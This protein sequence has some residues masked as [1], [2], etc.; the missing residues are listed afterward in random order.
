MAWRGGRLQECYKGK[1]DQDVCDSFRGLLISDHM[2]KTLTS[3]LQLHLNERYTAYVT[4]NQFGAVRRRGTA[5]AS[6]TLRSFMDACRLMGYSIAIIFVDLSK[7]FDLIVRQL[8]LGWDASLETME[9]KM[10]VLTSLGLPE[11]VAGKIASYISDHGCVL[12][13]MGVDLSVIELI[14]SLH[15]RAWFQ[16]RGGS[17]FLITKTGSRQGCKLG[18]LVFNLLYAAVLGQF[19]L[20]CRELGVGFYLEGSARLRMEGQPTKLHFADGPATDSNLTYALDVAYVDD[21]A[22]LLAGSSARR[23]VAIIPD[24]V[25][26]LFCT[27]QDFA[28]NV[29]W[30]PGKTEAIL[31]LRGKRSDSVRRKFVSAGGIALIPGLRSL[32]ADTDG[33]RVVKEYKHLGSTITAD[34][35]ENP[36]VLRRTRAAN[37]AYA[38]IAITVFGNPGLPTWKRSELARSLVFS[39]LLFNVHV[40][41]S[42]SAWAYAKL[43][44]VYMKVLRRI[45]GCVRYAKS[46]DGCRNKS[47]LEVRVGLGANALWVV[48]LGMRLTHLATIATMEDFCLSKLL[49][50]AAPTADAARMPWINLV[51]EDLLVVWRFHGARLQE[52]GDPRENIGNWLSFMGTYPLQWKQLLKRITIHAERCSGKESAGSEC[53]Q[54]AIEV[55]AAFSCAACRAIGQTAAFATQMALQA[56]QRKVHKVR[57]EVRCFID[58]SKECPV[59]GAC[60]AS[61]LRVIAHASEKRCRGKTRMTCFQAIQDGAVPRLPDHLVLELDEQDKIIRRDARRAGR[62]TPIAE[63]RASRAKV[64][65]MRAA[66]RKVARRIRGKMPCSEVTFAS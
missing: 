49:D 13:Q 55:A 14:R 8:V 45:C 36:E 51:L 53:A 2:G 5:L 50:V 16:V 43:N 35:V 44:G 37:A 31:V 22:V 6:H 56:H 12:E 7:A 26:T 28:L 15:D 54:G 38:P 27:F 62:T 23:L 59:C 11:D 52:L 41:S 4:V 66:P 57:T 48:I 18:A 63:F 17:A 34:G 1:G 30:K 32:G 46:Y 42:I 25:K 33:L 40:W 21:E 3:L 58:G 61:R 60:F 19:R 47:D 10:G 64:R 29:N 9:Q 24:V 20:R 65:A 39:L